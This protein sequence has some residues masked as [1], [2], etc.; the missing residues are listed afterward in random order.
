MLILLSN[1]LAATA[2]TVPCDY[3]PDE[4]PAGTVP[5]VEIDQTGA[6]TATIA[7]VGPGDVRLIEA[8]LW[9]A[10]KRRVRVPQLHDIFSVIAEAR[11]A[12]M[13]PNDLAAYSW[14][15][16][17]AALPT[18]LRIGTDEGGIVMIGPRVFGHARTPA[19][20]GLGGVAIR[21]N[22]YVGET[23]TDANGFYELTVPWN[24]PAEVE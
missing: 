11:E 2:T 10:S 8:A 1:I 13:D 7:W 18:E 17:Y 22:P 16:V 23:V 5:C 19:G 20:Q 15:A 9:R 14:P 21:T 24:W 12:G 6:M 3:E 4:L